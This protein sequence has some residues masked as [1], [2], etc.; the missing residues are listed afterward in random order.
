M[1]K[2]IHDSQ[3][4]TEVPAGNSTHDI[5]LIRVG[6][7]CKGYPIGSSF[8]ELLLPLAPNGSG[9]ILLEEMHNNKNYLHFHTGDYLIAKEI[10]EKNI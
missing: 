9:F 2:R 8:I 4:K 7:G 5:F 3:S 1:E 6:N 10:S